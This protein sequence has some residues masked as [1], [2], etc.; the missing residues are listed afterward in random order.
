MK[1]AIGKLR[2]IARSLAL[3]FE[4][5]A[6]ARLAL[7][8]VFTF[9]A[10]WSFAIA[11]GVYGF[12]AHGI[13]GVGIVA[14]IRYL[15]GA[16]ASPIAGVLI[17]RQSRRDVL[18]VSA[19]AMAMVLIG[20][21]VAVGL[22]APTAVVF[23]FP[24]LYAI[25]S[26][27]YSPAE[28]AMS[29]MLAQT[30]QQLS[31]GNV[32]DSVMENTGSL[33]GAI[34]AGILLTATSPTF[35]FGV[36]AAVS[37]VVFL[38]L[39]GVPRDERPAYLDRTGELAGARREIAVGL[40][41][42]AAHPAL[43]L[44]WM[45]TAAV[46][47]FEGFAEVIV[48][49]LALHVL[50]LADGSVGFLKAGWE[51]GA[52]VGGAGLMLILDRGRLVIAIAGGSLLMGAAAI[53]PGLVSEPVAAYA[54]WFAIG[55]GF[56]FVE[57]AAKTLTQRLGDDETMGRLL[58]LLQAG[59]LAALAVGSLCAIVLDE[60]LHTQGALIVLG[61]AMPLFVLLCWT[62]LRA[63]EVGA[64]VA[65][66]PYALLR[67]N[68]IFEPLPMA[69]VER[70][71]HDLAPVDL[72]GGVDV[73]VQGEVGDR[74]YLIESGQV[75]VFEHG[76]FRRNEGPGESFGEIAL[77]HDV[78]RTATVRTT[79]PTRLLQLEREQFLVA[80][81]GHRRSTQV[82]H[83]VVTDRWDGGAGEALAPSE[84]AP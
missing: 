42:L 72:E 2:M 57:V 84:S 67:H 39:I 16:V 81:T 10:A 79:E 35:V 12:E 23:V 11:L 49:S 73:I 80:V 32:N 54:G 31:A 9:F 3:D 46:L 15:P 52:V 63:Y 55:I 34:G 24:G 47:L 74:F 64:P 78:P 44:A 51:L 18:V 37:V 8:K 60:L 59:K 36:C 50:E 4:S 25:A 26:A 68:S 13:V 28:S 70:L 48:V 58:T 22:G 66:V 71:S 83:T 19:W 20:A 38:L 69:T 61:A 53:L 27:G 6:R 40:R 45:T 75:E 56:V 41:T 17:D 21:T 29:P 62:R 30:P 14:L 7:G 5:P 77:L 82:A 76:E 33:L 65:A 43:R 1:G